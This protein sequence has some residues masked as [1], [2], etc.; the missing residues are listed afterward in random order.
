M[1]GARS[2]LH[3]GNVRAAEF[4]PGRH[5]DSATFV[6]EQR[7]RYDAKQLSAFSRLSILDFLTAAVRGF[8]QHTHGERIAIDGCNMGIHTT[9]FLT[10]AVALFAQD[11]ARVEPLSLRVTPA[12][13]SSPCG[14]VAKAFIEPNEENRSLMLI[15]ESPQFRRASRVQLEGKRAARTHSIVFKDLEAGKYVISVRLK[16]AGGRDIVREHVVVVKP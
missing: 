12:I 9:L 7:S 13:C 6:R 10:T 16:R 14:V 3:A 5:H 4:I 2:E 11:A 8:L 15:A 1:N